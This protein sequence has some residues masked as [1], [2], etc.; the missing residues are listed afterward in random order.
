MGDG[1]KLS[2]HRVVFAFAS[3]IQVFVNH[4][5]HLIPPPAFVPL[6]LYLITALGI[7]IHFAFRILEFGDFLMVGLENEGGDEWYHSFVIRCQSIALAVGRRHLSRNFAL[8]HGR[9]SYVA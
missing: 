7:G 5:V 2:S 3:H 9:L 4:F 1:S 6:A 8:F